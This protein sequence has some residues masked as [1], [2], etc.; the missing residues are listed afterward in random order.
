[1]LHNL[2]VFKAGM[3][4]MSFQTHHCFG[5]YHVYKNKYKWT[6][7]T[8]NPHPP[9]SQITMFQD[10]NTM[11]ENIRTNLQEIMLSYKSH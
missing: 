11:S 2:Q 1:M 8:P 4:V 3:A 7:S 5:K 10:D 6:N 9:K